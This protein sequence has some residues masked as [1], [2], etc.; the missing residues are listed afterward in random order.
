MGGLIPYKQL[1]KPLYTLELLRLIGSYRKH[2]A[3]RYSW[4]LDTHFKHDD[5]I[6]R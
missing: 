2:R 1:L 6:V 5:V 4:P 3:R